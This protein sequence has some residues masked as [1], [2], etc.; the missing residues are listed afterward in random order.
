MKRKL[1]SAILIVALAAS[2]IACS[3][4]DKSDSTTGAADN[5]PGVEETDDAPVDETDPS[6]TNVSVDV[7]KVLGHLIVV[8]EDLQENPVTAVKLVGN[9]TGSEDDI[10]GLEP[11]ADSIRCIFEMNEWISIY[12]VT[13]DTYDAFSV[14]VMPHE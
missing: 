11:S 6:G 2:A 9:L 4:K 14:F 5:E 7:H 12:P 10:N 3:K 13:T 1:L 8:N